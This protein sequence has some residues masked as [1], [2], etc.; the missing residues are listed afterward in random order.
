MRV[1]KRLR[2]V[3]S[4]TRFG[5]AEAILSLMVLVLVV[6]LLWPE[7]QSP[8]IDQRAAW[9]Q[10][11]EEVERRHSEDLEERRPGSRAASADD[12]HQ[13]SQATPPNANRFNDKPERRALA[14]PSELADRYDDRARQPVALPVARK[15]MFEQL[16]LWDVAFDFEQE[17]F[18][19]P[20]QVD[21]DSKVAE[22]IE[23]VALGVED[24]KPDDPLPSV[25]HAQQPSSSPAEVPK[26]KIKVAV[27]SSETLDL[28]SAAEHPVDDGDA[29]PIAALSGTDGFEIESSA[30]THV[31]ER[32]RDDAPSWL[33]N[34]VTASLVEDR[35]VIAVV[36]DD[37]GVNRTNTKALNALP[38]P[39]TLAFLPYAGKIDAQTNA[40]REAGHEL[41]VHLPMEPFGSAWPGPEALITSL[42]HDE[43]LKRL[44]TNLDGIKGYVG[45]NNHMGSRLTTDRGR[46][47]LV[48]R[49]LRK[50][51]VL[52][53]DSKTSS[54]SIAGEMASRNGVPNTTRDVFLDHVIDID[55]IRSQMAQIERF[56]RRTGSAVAIGHPHTATI[57]AL[58][59]WLPKLEERGFTLAPLSAVI[60]RRAC[61]DELLITAKACGQYL[62]AQK[63]DAPSIAAGGG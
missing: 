21:V 17:L 35:P 2:H 18:D 49:E 57:K 26:P 38:A 37:L 4:P 54:R 58:K 32:P 24:P 15:E 47:D 29:A 7:S 43:F 14:K 56:A 51:D 39:L 10:Q 46:M 20:S 33:R 12:H 53:L 16:A 3:F 36:I 28:Q 22:P 45:V 52:F 55:K 23:T 30:S 13:G 50:R 62:Q 44:K 60:A 5:A 9:L 48:M 8:Q 6:W 61:H 42:D 59:E 25:D 40:A 19:V 63:P 34:A 11:L 31:R 41:M 1:S 27:Y